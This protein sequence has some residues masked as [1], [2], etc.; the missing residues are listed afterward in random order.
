MPKIT[1]K[2][3][4]HWMGEDCPSSE[5]IRDYV[6]FANGDYKPEVLK[7]DILSTWDGTK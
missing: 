1:Y 5:I 3:V 7:K 2:M 4:K 6:D